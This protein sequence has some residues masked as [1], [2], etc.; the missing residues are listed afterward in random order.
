[1]NNQL[2]AVLQNPQSW[3]QYDQQTQNA[4]ADLMKKRDEELSQSTI[5]GNGDTAVAMNPQNQLSVLMQP[6]M[7]QQMPQN[8]IRN[9]STGSMTELPPS[10]PQGTQGPALDY[11]SPIEIAGAGKGYR[12]KGDPFSAMLDN[13]SK[14]S[15][16]GD[17][18]A[19]NQRRMEDI[20]MQM[21]QANL[22]GQNIENQSKQT[23]IGRLAAPS[24]YRY[25]ASGNLEAIPGGPADTAVAGK[26]K[27]PTEDQAKNRQLYERTTQQLPIALQTFD[28]MGK[29]G[30]QVGN[31]T[32]ASWLTSPEFQRG[33]A[34]LK[35]IAASYLYSVSGATANPGEVANLTSTLRPRI[36]ES[37]ESIADKKARLQQMVSSINTRANPQTAGQTSQPTTASSVPTATG[38][39]GQKL[40]LRNGQWSPQ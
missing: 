25:S 36:G 2:Q 31:L 39:N 4:L 19:T 6:Q 7:R 14:V 16:G 27:P 38:P 15:L 28:S 10:Q 37:A 17:V 11:S 1:M 9:N 34:A 3:G 8:Y 18:A 32:G 23:A 20:K 5:V 35:D 29:L 12:V 24:G 21:A 13:G 26:N 33:D 30:N 40:Y 22:T